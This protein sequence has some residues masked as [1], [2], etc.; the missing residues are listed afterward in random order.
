MLQLSNISNRAMFIGSLSLDNR[1][2]MP[3]LMSSRPGGAGGWTSGTNRAF[4][5]QV[6]LNLKEMVILPTKIH[7]DDGYQWLLM[8]LLM[9]DDDDNYYIVH[10]SYSHHHYLLI[11]N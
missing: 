2:R 11:S 3:K 8:V 10:F 7:D 4:R 5:S 6:I 1:P 9:D